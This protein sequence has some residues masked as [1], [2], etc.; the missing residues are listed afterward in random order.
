MLFANA[1]LHT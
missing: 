1:N